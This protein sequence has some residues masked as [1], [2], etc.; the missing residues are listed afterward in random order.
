M[1]NKL[2]SLYNFLVRFS[3]SCAVRAPYQIITFYVQ[4][5][6]LISFKVQNAFTSAYIKRSFYYI[7]FSLPVFI[8]TR[9]I[10]YRKF[11]TMA[12][13]DCWMNVKLISIF[14]LFPLHSIPAERLLF[15]PFLPLRL[16]R[17]ITFTLR[18][19]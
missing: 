14:L 5:L 7:H 10:N 11:S 2:F 18:L 19:R 9:S 3:W 17:E 16:C 12:R 4:V 13:V 15:I 1:F 8:V 6:I